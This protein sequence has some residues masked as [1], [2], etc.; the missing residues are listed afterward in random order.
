MLHPSGGENVASNCGALRTLG[1]QNMAATD[2]GEARRFRSTAVHYLAGRPPYPS[3]L[4][5]RVAVLTGLPRGGRVLDLGCG[6]AQLALAFAVLGA[7]VLAIDPESE[8]LRVARESAGGTTVRFLHASSADLGPALG[9]FDLVVM[10][11]SFHWMDRAETLRRLDALIQPG[12]AVVLFGDRHPA[13][14]DNAWR[15]AWRDVLGGFRAPGPGHPGEGPDWVR[16]EAVLLDSAFACVDS[17]A[18]IERRQVSVATL[19]TRALSQSTHNPDSLGA[20]VAALEAEVTQ[21]LESFAVEGMITEVVESY[22]LI[23]TRPEA[24]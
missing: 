20:R 1:E 12:G 6:P 2:S 5:A 23:A 13:V 19:V 7:D 16:H 11:R 3:R 4:I 8:M 21:T 18:V 17:V 24:V 15:A 9:H 22:A 10:G 14:P